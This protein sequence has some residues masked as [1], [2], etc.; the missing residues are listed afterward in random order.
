MH[1]VIFDNE[2]F[3]DQSAYLRETPLPL[4]AYKKTKVFLSS[5]SY[6][7]VYNFFE[8][9]PQFNTNHSVQHICQLNTKNLRKTL[10]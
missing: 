9:T 6:R 1:K 5:I 8:C 2:L 7:V 10:K 3:A 4:A